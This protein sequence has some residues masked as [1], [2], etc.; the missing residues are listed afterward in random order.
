MYVLP[1]N[2]RQSNESYLM[3]M[4]PPPAVMRSTDADTTKDILGILGHIYR[5]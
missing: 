5:D 4:A 2:E 3:L 1:T